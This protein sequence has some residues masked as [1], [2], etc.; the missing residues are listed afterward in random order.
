LRQG[1]G[2]YRRM[3]GLSKPGRHFSARPPLVGARQQPV[4]RPEAMQSW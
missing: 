1:G 2:V 3:A 4:M